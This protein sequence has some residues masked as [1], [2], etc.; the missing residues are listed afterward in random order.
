MQNY[1]MSEDPNEKKITIKKNGNHLINHT[2]AREKWGSQ[3]GARRM[4]IPP[5]SFIRQI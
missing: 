3:R 2:F 1:F 4:C 5:L